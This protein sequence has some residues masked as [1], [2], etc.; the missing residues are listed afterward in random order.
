[1]EVGEPGGFDT[2]SDTDPQR[3]GRHRLPFV[4]ARQATGD[5]ALQ[6]LLTRLGDL[7]ERVAR[8]DVVHHDAERPALLVEVEL[9]VNADL[10][11][12]TQVQPVGPEL[13]CEPG[14][15]VREEL[16]VELRLGT[17]LPLDQ[18][19]VDVLTGALET[20][21]LASD[22][23][24]VAETAAQPFVDRVRELADREGQIPRLVDGR[25]VELEGWL[26]HAD[27]LAT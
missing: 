2:C 10:H 12:V 18:R 7:A 21:D 14:E 17:P 25:I 4:H 11:P 15:L 16:D 8:V 6:D 26:R 19:E 9:A 27:Q 13:R 23:D 5:Q 3:D 22:P 24:P 1:M 20:V